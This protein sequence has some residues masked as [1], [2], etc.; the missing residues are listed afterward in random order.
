MIS[1]Y[2]FAHFIKMQGGAKSAAFFH[3]DFRD[4]EAYLA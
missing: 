1:G 2:I 3:F 4:C